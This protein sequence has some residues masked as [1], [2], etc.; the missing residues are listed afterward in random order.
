MLLKINYNKREM[1][2]KVKKYMTKENIIIVAVII[3]SVLM[4]SLFVFDKI[5]YKGVDT[6]YHL[7]R[8]MGIVNSWKTGN[9][10][11]YIHTDTN[12][13]G[14][15]MGFFYGNISVLLP[16]L[17]Y[18]VGTNLIVAYKIFIVVC[19]FGTA[20]SMYVC[21]KK[22]S[23]SKY[24]GT[25]ST[26][27]Y[28]T[29]S[30]RII[31]LVTKAF[32]GEVLSFIFIPIIILGLYELI[33]NDEKKWWILS[34]GFVG[35]LN[36]NLVMTEIMIAISAVIV[37]CNIKEIITNKKRLLGFIKATIWALLI[38]AAFWMPMLEQLKNNKFQMTTLMET[39]KPTRWLLDIEKIF[40]GTIQYKNN[41]AAAYGSGFIF[42]IIIVLRLF[43]KENN[44]ATKFCDISLFTGLILLLCMTKYFPW[45]KIIKIGEMIQFPSRMEV[46]VAAFFSIGCGI[47]CHYIS[48]KNE[49]K[50]KLLF[51]AILIFQCAFSVVYLKA[52]VKALEKYNGVD[53]K[54]QL[55]IEEDFIYNICDGVYLPEGAENDAFDEIKAKR[56]EIEEKYKDN[57]RSL[58][59]EHSRNGLIETIK[60]SNNDYENTYV[61]IPRYYYYGYT[62][63]SEDGKTQYK[64][65]KTEKGFIRI[66]LGDIKEGTVK[67]YYKKTIIQRISAL[68]S[69]ITIISSMLIFCYKYK[70]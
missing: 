48:N 37:I 31:T 4:S 3:L 65:E 52:C 62:A 17:L 34:L 13:F 67:L 49:K 19:G 28:T 23:G 35:I 5:L 15:A 11:A 29:C 32:I 39:Y 9:I 1:K 27:L 58:K 22:I 8:I 24:A 57:N 21:S 6:E 10:P 63:E 60:F 70:K 55:E 59:W 43:V 56:Y 61:E 69:I 40:S 36:S 66:Y 44:K 7:S 20:V 14:Y 12:G 30:Y 26:V 16:C 33:F 51:I 64:I 68:I 45:K 47:I 38:S 18:L 46:P 54:E 50:R 25:I 2:T 41:M 42:A 53:S